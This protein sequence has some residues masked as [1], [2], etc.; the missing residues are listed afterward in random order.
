[1]IE[2]NVP[3]TVPTALARE[4]T[5][6]YRLATK[7]TGRLFLFAGDQKVEHLNNDFKGDDIS[8]EDQ[9]PEHL[10]KIANQAE[11]GVFATQLGLID[12]YG[13]DYKNIPYVVKLNSRTNLVSIKDHDPVSYG[14]YSLEDVK[15]FKKQSKL[16][17]V[18]IG[19]TVYLG[20]EY[21]SEILRE[22]AQIIKDAHAQGLLA[23]IWM[24]PRGKSIPNEDDI[25]IIAGGAGV[26]ACLGSDFVKVK[27]PYTGEEETAKE[28][29]TVVAAAGHTKVICVGGSRLSPEELLKNIDQQIHIAQTAGNAVGRNLHQYSLPD[30][31]RL[32]RAIAG[33]IYHDCSLA[34]AL[35]LLEK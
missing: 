8:I 18:G 34:K 31:V 3:L 33:I 22:A 20:G 35:K 16:N 26:A 24:Y 15:N 9:D 23:I 13:S 11:I 1:M 27:Y 12:K 6:N 2:V 29:K 10:F 19:Y 28:F 7:D 4:Y 32:A 25:N 5:K 30:A 21:E 14:W 17:I